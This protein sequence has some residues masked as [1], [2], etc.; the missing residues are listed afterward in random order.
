MADTGC[1]D[2]AGGGSPKGASRACSDGGAAVGYFA[3]KI[4]HDCVVVHASKDGPQASASLVDSGSIAF[5]WTA[6]G[7]S[8]MMR[9]IPIALGAGLAWGQCAMCSR[10]A[11]AQNRGRQEALNSG[12]A[13]IAVPLLATGLLIARLAYRR[14]ARSTEITGVK[15]WPDAG[16]A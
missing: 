2:C 9:L 13:V 14:R 15:D 6:S 7:R 10:N 5:R 3:G 11:E 1:A 12:I 16:A 8:A 4:G